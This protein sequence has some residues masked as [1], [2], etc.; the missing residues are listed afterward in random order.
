MYR[1]QLKLPPIKNSK[2]I[3]ETILSALS[4]ALVSGIVVGILQQKKILELKRK[5]KEA[6][7]FLLD[8]EVLEELKPFLSEEQLAII[9]KGKEIN[10]KDIVYLRGLI[11]DPTPDSNGKVFVELHNAIE[12]KSIYVLA[13]FVFRDGLSIIRSKPPRGSWVRVKAEVTSRNEDGTAD[14]II[15]NQPRKVF[16]EGMQL[17]AG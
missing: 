11:N 17:T 8:S 2:M 15:N 13:S 4:G 10:K 5:V 12:Y 1:R 3:L 16:Q 7:A 9:E 14:V 6:S